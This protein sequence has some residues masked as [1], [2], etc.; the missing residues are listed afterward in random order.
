MELIIN[1]KSVFFR[2]VNDFYSFCGCFYF[3]FLMFYITNWNANHVDV[4]TKD[5]KAYYPLNLLFG[6]VSDFI[7]SEKSMLIIAGIH[8]L[9]GQFGSLIARRKHRIPAFIVTAI[10]NVVWR[11][12]NSV[13]I[14]LYGY[15]RGTFSKSKI[16]NTK[17]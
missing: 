8:W 17:G 5:T 2:I 1:K 15:T 7:Y 14:V 9:S 10:L 11:N 6:T 16:K 12:S 3:L 4:I 13:F